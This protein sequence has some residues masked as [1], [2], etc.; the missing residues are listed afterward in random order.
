MAVVRVGAVIELWTISTSRLRRAD[1]GGAPIPVG[2]G[3]LRGAVGRETSNV[4]HVLVVHDTDLLQVLRQV[5]QPLAVARVDAVATE[6]LHAPVRHLLGFLDLGGVKL[7][8]CWVGRPSSSTY[9]VDILWLLVW[10]HVTVVVVAASC[11]LLSLFCASSSVLLSNSI[12]ELIDSSLFQLLTHHLLFSEPSV[13]CL[14]TLGDILC[15][16]IRR[17]WLPRLGLGGGVLALVGC[18]HVEHHV[19]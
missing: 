11:L 7:N 12:F 19:V 14:A 4:V 18:S 3:V 9:V 1:L 16:R 5:L 15:V 6:L 2:V 17:R 8:L 10:V 13:F